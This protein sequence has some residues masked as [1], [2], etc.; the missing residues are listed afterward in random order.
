M[1]DFFLIQRQWEA[2]QKEKKNPLDQFL[3]TWKEMKTVKVD[4]EAEIDEDEE[5]DEDDE[6][7]SLKFLL[8]NFYCQSSP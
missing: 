4:D 5:E 6:K 3:K 7:V 8:Y 1:F 2:A